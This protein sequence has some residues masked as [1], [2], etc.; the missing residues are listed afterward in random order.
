MKLMDI[1]IKC[2][3]AVKHKFILLGCR[4]KVIKECILS[5]DEEKIRIALFLLRPRK[6]SFF[7]YSF[8]DKY[9]KNKIKVYYDEEQ[10]PYVIHNGYRLYMKKNWSI[11]WIKR[12]YMSLQWDQDKE[13]PHCYLL[14]KNR[15]PNE[16]DVI[17]DVGA[18][19]GIFTLDVINII[20]KA[21]LFEC[22]EE[23]EIPLRK[24]FSQWAE[25]IEIVK[26]YIGDKEDEQTVNL[27]KFF[28]N[29]PLNLLKADIEGA[30]EAMLSGGKCTFENKIEKALICTYHL[31]KAEER[32]CFHLKK[33]G[34]KCE[35]NPGY[36]L[37]IWNLETFKPPYVRHALVYGYKNK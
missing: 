36:A 31:P 2:I 3:R 1:F 26:K 18:A 28:Q 37:Y 25:K 15:Y 5:K 12:Y 29:K 13:S 11:D 20:E 21:Y 22:D 34:F 4:G 23:W 33:Y 27:D 7:P 9:R 6:L 19:E 32:I 17:A 14:N 16:G 24:T 35:Y 8:T 30:E 10:Y